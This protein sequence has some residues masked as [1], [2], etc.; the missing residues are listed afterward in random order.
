MCARFQVSQGGGTPP[1][2]TP[3][4]EQGQGRHSS[5]NLSQDDGYV[6]CFCLSSL[7]VKKPAVCLKR[8]AGGGCGRRESN[9]QPSESTSVGPLKKRGKL[10]SR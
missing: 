9:V 3:P 4:P 8:P 1:N 10:G 2:G 7:F 6:F 5:H